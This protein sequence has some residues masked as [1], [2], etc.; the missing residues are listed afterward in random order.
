MDLVCQA[1]QKLEFSPIF[2]KHIIES[3]DSPER[4][5]DEQRSQISFDEL[6]SRIERWKTSKE[7][8][9]MKGDKDKMLSVEL[10]IEIMKVKTYHLY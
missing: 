8:K 4:F 2:S 6:H 5:G 1:F 9:A 3:P 7:A 10:G